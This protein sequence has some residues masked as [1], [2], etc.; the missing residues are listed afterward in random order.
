M[1]KPSDDV[2]GAAAKAVQS[3]FET[4]KDAVLS[5][6]DAGAKS[7]SD[8]DLGKHASRMTEDMADRLREAADDIVTAAFEPSRNPNS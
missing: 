1:G 7:V 4:A 2:K 8:A 5:A 6:T 3:G